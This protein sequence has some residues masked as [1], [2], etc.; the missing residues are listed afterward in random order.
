MIHYSKIFLISL[1]FIAFTGCKEYTKLKTGTRRVSSELS[2]LKKSGS[3]IKNIGA[4]ANNA[5]SNK[6]I[7]APIK[8]KS[9]LNQY[10]YLY[11]WLN[12]KNATLKADNFQWD[13]SRNTYIIIDS[14]SRRLNPDVEVFGWHPYFMGELWKTYPYE[15]LSTISFFSYA[16]DPETGSYSNPDHINQW[17]NI[18]MVD[19]AHAHRKRALLTVSC[20]GERQSNRFLENQLAWKVLADS[21]S[22]LLR[23]KQA[24]G[25]ELDFR[26]FSESKRGTFVNFVQ[27]FRERMEKQMVD[28]L[29]Y[30]AISLPPDNQNQI[31][32]ISE[33]QVH[34]D[35]MVIRGYDLHELNVD[36]GHAAISPL[37]VENNDGYSLESIVT[38]YL[39]AGIDSSKT[40]LALPLYGAQWKGAS[41]GNDFYETNFDKKIT[42]REIKALYNPLDTTYELV[43]NLDPIT[44]TNYFNLEFPDNTNI[45]CWFDDDFTLGKKMN[46]ALSRKLK[47][48]GL[49]AL[50][51]DNGRSEIWDLVKRK[52]TT[53]TIEVTDPIVEMEGYPIKVASYIDKHS[54]LFLTASLILVFAFVIA[55]LIAFSDWRVRDSIFNNQFNHFVFIILSTLTILPFLSFFGLLGKGRWQLVLA[56][57][58]GIGIGYIIVQ[59]KVALSFKRP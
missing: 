16:I 21:V 1:L 36:K 32:D 50:G 9:I 48:V 52:F 2:L 49:W 57:L 56:F 23:E 4:N 33:I 53:D 18:A 42:Y 55:L 44:M 45:E 10:N 28:K 46:F 6:V 13:T 51:Y 8:Q 54:N 19:S 20:H 7:A 24:D 14:G 39:S 40:I 34:A 25:V 26:G 38:S 35:A 58:A 43:A 41:K 12:G 11:D 47:G 30:L 31:F 5:D 17:R 27:D 15:L 3:F 37:R 59:I 29:F 22:S